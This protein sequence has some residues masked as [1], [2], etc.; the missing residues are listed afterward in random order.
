MFRC[1][2]LLRGQ[3]LQVV[4]TV[5]V[6]IATGCVIVSGVSRHQ[7]VSNQLLLV[8]ITVIVPVPPTDVSLLVVS[9][10]TIFLC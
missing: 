9:A 4:I 8:V 10:T 6:P 1:S 7:F 3:L 5:V 2:V